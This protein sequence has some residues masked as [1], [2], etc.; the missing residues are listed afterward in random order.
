MVRRREK[1]KGS[2]L[3]GAVIGAVAGFAGIRALL[4]GSGAREETFSLDVE[5][6]EDG[7]EAVET[8]RSRPAP[9]PAAQL[10]RSAM[11][12]LKARWREAM[13]EGRTAAAERERELEAQYAAETKRMPEIEAKAI[14]LIEE[15]IE[16]QRDEH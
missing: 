9:T 8:F 15:R 10:F 12:S 3:L 6:T 2:F 1:G 13:S 7:V 4:A 16:Q 14:Q 11:D 5:A